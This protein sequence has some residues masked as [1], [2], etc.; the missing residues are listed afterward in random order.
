[1]FSRGSGSG[2]ESK[3]LDESFY[4][5]IV[6]KNNDP[7]KM[8]R[9][10][11]FIPEIS[12]QPY[13]EWFEEYERIYIK[14]PGTNTKKD[15]WNKSEIFEKIASNIPWAEPCFPLFG[16]S[17]NTRYFSPDDINT[18]SDS[19]YEDEEKGFGVIDENPPTLDKGLYSPAYLYEN[20]ETAVSDKFIN[21]ISNFSVRCNSYGF[22]YRPSKHVNKTKGMMGI[23]EVGSKVWVFHHQG[24]FQ[25]PVYFGVYQDQRSMALINEVDNEFL[26]SN[27]YP[28]EFE[29]KE[30][31]IKTVIRVD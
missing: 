12:N 14:T 16:E 7:L 11:V 29:N 10:K 5:G 28:S 31:N 3:R 20:K 17:G 24:D 19:N 27:T 8:N 13:K 21:P 9:I 18:I 23:P 22:S 6:V 26:I 30:K 25:S 1:M 4:K 15:T 2:L